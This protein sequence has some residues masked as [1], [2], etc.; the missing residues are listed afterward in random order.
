MIYCLSIGPRM[1]FNDCNHSASA[2][3][4]RSAI[5]RSRLYEGTSEVGGNDGYTDFPGG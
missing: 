1:L 4:L 2:I 5:H 3:S